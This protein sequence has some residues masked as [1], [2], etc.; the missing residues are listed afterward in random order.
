MSTR[1]EQLAG[2]AEFV[3]TGKNNG[4]PTSRRAETSWEHVGANSALLFFGETKI[5]LGVFGGTGW[6]TREMNYWVFVIVP[7][8]EEIIVKKGRLGES[9][10]V[11]ADMELFADFETS[12]IDI[13][14]MVVN[15][16]RMML[17][18]IF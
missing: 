18:I 6:V 4:L 14:R 3:C 13:D 16:V 1:E 10:F 7:I 2:G 5:A 15:R 8:V 17:A 11:Y 9:L 12:V